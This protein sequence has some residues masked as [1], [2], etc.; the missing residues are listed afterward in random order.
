[1][2]A[3]KGA[4]MKALR[5]RAERVGLRVVS[6]DRKHGT[7]EGFVAPGAVQE[8]AALQGAG[9]LAQALRPHFNVGSA[10]SHSSTPT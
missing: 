6:S 5:T 7:L 3:A 2:T 10:T 8:L 9:T 1:M 4:S